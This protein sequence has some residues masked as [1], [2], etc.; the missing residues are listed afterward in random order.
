MKT[1]LIETK[2]HKSILNNQVGDYQDKGRYYIKVADLGDESMEFLVALH[3]LCE[4]MLIKKKG[5][6]IKQV[7]DFDKAFEA[8]RPEGNTDEAGDD[9]A[10]VYKEC[11]FIATNIERQMA[12]HLGVDWKTYEEVINALEY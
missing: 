1:I 9:P 3:E 7:E 11:H 4:L 8:W 10:C 12:Q 6:T 2:P 5:I